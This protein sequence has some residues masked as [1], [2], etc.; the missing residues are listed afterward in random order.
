[1]MLE[2]NC[3]D[4][5]KSDVVRQMIANTGQTIRHLAS[6]EFQAQTVADYKF[7]G[8]LIRRLGLLAQ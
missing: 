4:A 1:V 3:A 8:E 5:I 2:R 7:K 6:A